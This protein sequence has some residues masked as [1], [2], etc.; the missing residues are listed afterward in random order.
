MAVGTAMSRE[1][2]LVRTESVG[3]VANRN[4]AVEVLRMRASRSQ[5]LSWSAWQA[6]AGYV[7][8]GGCR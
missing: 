8:R 7:R 2:V 5:P 3:V 4:A 6:S 1:Q